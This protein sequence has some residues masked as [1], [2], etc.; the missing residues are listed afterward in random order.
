MRRRVEGSLNRL[1]GTLGGVYL[2][3]ACYIYA[4]GWMD[5]AIFL[6][7]FLF[8]MFVFIS[9]MYVKSPKPIHNWAFTLLGQIFCAA[10]F[11]LLNFVVFRSKGGAQSEFAPLPALALFVFVWLNDS[12]AYLVG[13]MFGKHRLFE[14][15]SPKKSWEGFGRQVWRGVRLYRRC[16]FKRIYP[17]EARRWDISRGR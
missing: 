11:S 16:C 12:I 8:L 7:Y 4:N 14:R 9:G 3:L 17:R 1:V 6:P 15:I 10:S 2:F 13:S 5:D